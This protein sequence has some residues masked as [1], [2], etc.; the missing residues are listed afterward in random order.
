MK[1]ITK[2]FIIILIITIGIITLDTTVA[3]ICK[4]TPLIHFKEKQTDLDSWVD[5][6]IIID[7]YYCVKELDIVSVHQYIKGSKFTCPIDEE[8][9]VS[10][11]LDKTTEVDGFMCAQ[12]LEPFYSD[13]EYTYSWSC[14]KNNFIVIVFTN[15]ETMLVSEGL[16]NNIITI[17]DLDKYNIKY[18]KEANY[19]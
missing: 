14:I 5:K 13:A 15:G 19:D 18:Y 17:K 4:K 8:K 6:G 7:T 10:Y 9:K 2:I 12:A 16:K 11:I 3:L 1:K